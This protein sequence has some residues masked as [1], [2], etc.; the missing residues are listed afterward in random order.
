[1]ESLMISKTADVEIISGAAF[2]VSQE[3]RNILKQ[4]IP[5]EILNDSFFPKNLL[6]IFIGT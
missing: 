3:T 5:M 6:N 4:N 1:M 2:L